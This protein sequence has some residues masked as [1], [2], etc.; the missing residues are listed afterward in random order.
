MWRN[1]K[2]RRSVPDLKKQL[3]VGFALILYVRAT[4]RQQLRTAIATRCPDFIEA[5]PQPLPKGGEPQAGGSPPP[6]PRG[7]QTSWKQ[8]ATNTPPLGRGRG[9]A[10]RGLINYYEFDEHGN[11]LGWRSF[12][13]HRI[14]GWAAWDWE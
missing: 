5:H 1:K 3:S 6:A 7:A 2:L 4:G 14:V 8:A 11:D 10:T 13:A 12:Y 9:W